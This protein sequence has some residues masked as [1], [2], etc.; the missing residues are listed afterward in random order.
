MKDAPGSSETSV[1]T[2]VTR[3]N[4]PEDTFLQ[5]KK[6]SATAALNTVRPSSEPYDATQKQA[7]A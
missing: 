3:R 6:K 1:L 5:L 4:I 2:I 7:I